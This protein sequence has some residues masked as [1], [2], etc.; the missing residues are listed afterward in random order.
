MVLAIGEGE[1]SRVL[2]TEDGGATW[3]ETFRNTDTKAFYDCLAFFDRRHGLAMSDP[4]DGRF[5]ILSTSDGGRSW[6]VLPS[7]GMPDAQEGRLGSRPAANAWSPRGRATCGSPRAA[8]H[9][10]A[11]CTPPTV[12]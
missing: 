2:R 8:A 6:K 1:A 9:M 7:A 4:V 10:R 5:R 12:G 3:T 11:Y